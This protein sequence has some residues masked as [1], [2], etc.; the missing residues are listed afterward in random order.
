M[1][2]CKG[3]ITVEIS[4]DY[5][6]AHLLFTPNPEGKLWTLK[7]I[8]DFLDD[9][10]IV[11][12]LDD[13]AISRAFQNFCDKKSFKSDNIAYG[14]PPETPKPARIELYEN[15]IP[16]E[17]HSVMQ[18]ALE[19]A[20]EPKIV[21]IETIDPKGPFKKEKEEVRTQVS[22]NPKVLK[23]GYYRKGE[24]LGT[25]YDVYEGKAGTSVEGHSISPGTT[26][27]KNSVFYLGDGLQK[28]K[29]NKVCAEYNGFL[30]MG[31]NWADLVPF[32]DHTVELSLSKDKSNC[33][34]TITP[35]PAHLAPPSLDIIYKQV[36]KLNYPKEYLIKSSILESAVK[37]IIASGKKQI[38]SIS[39]SRD[40]KIDFQVNEN[41][42]E[43][44]LHLVK[45]RGKGSKL[46]LNQISKE[47][48]SKG[49]K[50]LQI[51]SLKESITSFYFSDEMETTIPLCKGKEPERGNDRSINFSV[52]FQ[53]ENFLAELKEYLRER[54]ELLQPYSSIKPFPPDK[55][56][57]VALVEEGDRLFSLSALQKGKDGRDVFGKA[58]PGVRGND[59]VLH[60]YEGINYEEGMAK[61]S[62]RGILEI[63]NDQEKNALYA[64]IRQ[65]KDSQIIV[66]VS[67]NRMQASVN[68]DL[69]SGSGLYASGE[70][71]HNALDQV[72]VIEGILE[73][74][75]EE[76]AKRSHEGEVL[77]D[78]LVAEGKYPLDKDREMRLFLDIDQKERNYAPV[79]I[80]E[81]IGEI[82]K[83]NNSSGY[84]V[85]GE[86]LESSSAN[87]IEIGENIEIKEDEETG[88]QSLYASASG[89]LFFDS[90]KIFIKD[91]LKIEG[92]LSS[93]MGKI[94]FPGNI[95]ITG[96]VQ[97]QA[98]VKAGENIHVDHVVEAALL[99]ADG[100]IIVGKGIKGNKKAALRSQ[101]AITLNYAEES[102]LMSVEK[103]DV[104]KALLHC[105]VKCNNRLVMPPNGKVI[106]GSLKC[107][108]GLETGNL[109]ND[110]GTHTFVSFGQDYLVED[111]IRQTE[112]DIEKI[113]Q[114]ML[115]I[116]Q[117]IEKIQE[118]GGKNDV[119]MEAREKKKKALK[120][121]EKKNLK[122][123]LLRE[124]FEMHY[125]SDILVRDNLFPGVV[126]ESHG[127]TLEINETIERVKVFFD[128]NTGKIGYKKL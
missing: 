112:K 84:T 127:R 93:T 69:P 43:A 58:I 17:M 107:K 120:M 85:L 48:N 105:N 104:K 11:F 31:E 26:L 23:Q 128:Q 72:N 44:N 61:A 89:Q 49:F 65:H 53:S 115:K 77:S 60:L 45:G 25:Y 36:E 76:A 62:Q 47:L 57:Q 18:E 102:L 108:E 95:H 9:Q 42:T 79:K 54:E 86:I 117:I 19:K 52:T 92:N 73:D 55:V 111:Q 50:G 13:Q 21:K 106:G 32:N 97:S 119:L 10:K 122:I 6:S 96:S 29:A 116:D 124:K 81:K 5:L 20:A 80:S 66:R 3:K 90:K 8:N 109:G 33:L 4:E 114:Q 56:E 87:S 100:N 14:K 71:I 78:F 88:I 12:G 82:V 37:K 40:S 118:Q 64:R 67:E 63:F 123:F 7:G 98:V 28:D 83:A 51:G 30:R 35:G 22:I 75:I 2:E 74:R 46:D 15:D 59:P 41:L 113:Q 126:F 34:L 24:E 68:I 99:S 101:K 27:K 1:A 91:T 70:R 121:M 125:D 110:R 38:F 94:I 103:L 39:D 16:P